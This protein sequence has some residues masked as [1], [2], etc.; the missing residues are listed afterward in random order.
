MKFDRRN[1]FEDMGVKIAG[2]DPAAL[3]EN[4]T[5]VCILDE[6]PSFF[7]LYGDDEIVETVREADIIAIDA[8]LM[9]YPKV[10]DVDMMLRKYGALPPTMGGMRKLTER[11]W[12]LREALKRKSDARIIEVFPTATAKIMGFYSRNWREME[13]MLGL[14]VKN[15]HEL[16]AYICALTAMM[17]LKGD[18]IEVG[19]EGKIVIPLYH[20]DKLF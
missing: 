2:I 1:F 5:G 13:E 16:D 14:E 19:R 9:P 7:T 12:K 6:K 20:E 17:Y 10:R 15:K 11:A 4:P 3:P 18:A 8:P